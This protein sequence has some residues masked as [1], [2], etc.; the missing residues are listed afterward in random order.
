MKC[1]NCN[2]Q[3]DVA[4]LLGRH[5]R[6]EGKLKAKQ[7]WTDEEDQLIQETLDQSLNQVVPLFPNRTRASVNC[8]RRDHRN[9]RIDEIKN[10]KLLCD[11]GAEIDIEELKRHHKDFRWSKTKLKKLKG[12]TYGS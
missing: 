7:A 9:G 8:R 2:K 1:E 4:S 3:L 6:H 12:Y 10:S 5:Y 11:C